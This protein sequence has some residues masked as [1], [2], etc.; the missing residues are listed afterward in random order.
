MIA[1]KKSD[2]LDLDDI[3]DNLLSEEKR[4]NDKNDKGKEE[5]ETD[6]MFFNKENKKVKCFSCNKI[7]HIE[8]D[9]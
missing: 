9:C 4:R 3:I 2:D 5:N 8:K 1:G 7:V 6:Q